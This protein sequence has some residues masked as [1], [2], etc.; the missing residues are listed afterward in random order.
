MGKQN[1]FPHVYNYM[2][3]ARGR[4]S[5][6]PTRVSSAVA[7]RAHR[8][9]PRTRP[10]IAVQLSRTAT[11]QACATP[12]ASYLQHFARATQAHPQIICTA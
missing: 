8:P 2:V 6:L 7:R 1:K 5:P 10:H 3:C 9:Q 11:G 12:T 4:V